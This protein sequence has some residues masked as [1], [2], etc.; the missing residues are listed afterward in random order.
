MKITK[1]LLVF[2]F[3]LPAMSMKGQKAAS[4][5]PALQY[6]KQ[7]YADWNLAEEDVAD[8][9][10][11]DDYLSLHSNIRHVYLRQRY[12]GIP[13]HNAAGGIHFDKNGKVI[14]KTLRFYPNISSLTNAARPVLSAERALQDAIKALNLRPS[15]ASILIQEQKQT[16][17]LFARLD[18]SQTDIPVQLNYYPIESRLRLAWTVGIYPIGSPDYWQF[19]IDAQTGSVLSKE[20]LTL[21]CTFEHEEHQHPNDCTT[22][23]IRT[24][25]LPTEE[26][27]NLNAAE[28]YRVFPSPVESPIHGERRLLVDPADPLASPY[29]WHDTNAVAGPDFFTTK[30]NNVHAYFDIQNNNR[31]DGDEVV[32][33][34]L[35]FDFPYDPER[36]PTFNKDAS[37]T[38]LFYMNNLVHD[39]AYHYGFDEQAGNFQNN[40]YQRGGRDGDYIKAEAMDGSGINNA[41]FLPLPDGNPGRMQMYLWDRRNFQYLNIEAPFSLSGSYIAGIARFSPSPDSVTIR[42]RIVEAYDG[43]DTPNLGCETIVNQ[44]EVKGS[45]AMVY[46]GDC[47]FVQKVL[48]AQQAGAIGVIIAN[49][50]NAPISPGGTAEDSIYIPTIG[51]SSSSAERIKSQLRH[52]VIANIRRPEV[53]PTATDASFDNGIIAHEYAHGISHRLTGGPSTSACLSNDEQMGEGWSDFFGL[54][55]STQS[56]DPDQRTKGIGNFANGSQAFGGGIRRRPYSPLKEINEFTYKDIINTT[57]PHRVGEVWASIL[58][59]LYWAFSD[60]YGWDPDIITGNGGNNMAI[61]LVMDGMKYQAC[62]PGFV[63]G[64]DAI[65]KA[66]SINYNAANQCLIWKVFARR[67]LGWSADQGDPDNRKDGIEAFDLAPSCIP[68]LKVYKEAT[69]SIG[70]G[71]FI[72]YKITVKND[73]PE[74]VTNLLL[75]DELPRN[76]NLLNFSIRGAPLIDQNVNQLLF[77]IDLIPPGESADIIYKVATAPELGSGRIFFDDFDNTGFTWQARARSG[78]AGWRIITDTIR[79]YEKSWFVPNSNRTNTHLLELRESIPVLGEKPVLRFHH[80]YVTEPIT[81]GGYL[82]IS[83]DAGRNWTPLRPDQFLRNGYDGEIAFSTVLI[84]GINGFFG[85]RPDFTETIVDLGEYIGEEVRIRFQFLSDSEPDNEDAFLEGIGWTIDDIEFMDLF[86]YDTEVCVTTEQGDFVCTRARE[87]GT[88]VNAVDELTSAQ[89]VELSKTLTTSV[90]PNPADQFLQIQVEARE[91][92]GKV[93]FQL[94]APDGRLVRALEQEVIVGNQQITLDVSQLPAGLYWLILQ[95]ERGIESQKIMIK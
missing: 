35:N 84:H 11:T 69:P 31:P 17:Y 33:E 40:N 64:R 67:G 44:D 6:V 32:A 73:K 78:G 12:K 25:Q 93:L 20:N 19:Q 87:L 18:I 8:I 61:Q 7:S 29:G 79:N 10:V 14:H 26:I 1:L 27:R 15:K 38:Q 4:P 65:L 81:D 95:H 60:E 46:R 43:S 83:T 75:S 21:H 55:L 5:N 48:N 49:Y 68:E 24:Q 85:N 53:L 30:G 88:T 9:E 72:Q 89:E 36:E 94:Q 92:L 13:I 39:F 2:C 74:P 41:N 76:S 80:K 3:S 16:D 51:I 50:S 23:T 56:A 57:G 71:D 22:K 77:Q 91:E 34:D 58:W 28:A 63:D 82:E 70:A 59:D 37:L 47:F 90:F 54:V 52:G 86:H 42:G 66:D 62:D 45:I